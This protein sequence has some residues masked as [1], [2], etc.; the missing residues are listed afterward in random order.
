MRFMT[1]EPQFIIDLVCKEFGMNLEE[2]S[3]KNRHQDIVFARSILMYLLRMNTSLTLHQ[4]ALIVRGNRKEPLDHSTV[5]HACNKVAKMLP[6]NDSMLATVAK[7]ENEIS[8]K[9]VE[10]LEKAEQEMFQ[11]QKSYLEIMRKRNKVVVPDDEPEPAPITR[12][13]GES[14]HEKLMRRYL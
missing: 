3:Q 9:R 2:I 5:I 1:I 4:I 10:E 12:V 8:K 14:E 7:L 13:A 11:R 6:F